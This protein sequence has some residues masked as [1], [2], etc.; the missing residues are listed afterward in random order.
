[1]FSSD[2][3]F[4]PAY[5]VL[6]LLTFWF[7]KILGFNKNHNVVFNPAH[8]FFIGSGIYLINKS[9]Q[10]YNV[11]FVNVLFFANPFFFQI[12]PYHL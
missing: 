6:S 4:P 2:C 3:F 12:Y 9:Y 7:T 1:M 10:S 8:G 5:T 11:L